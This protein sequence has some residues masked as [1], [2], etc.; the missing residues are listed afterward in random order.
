[1]RAANIKIENV[2]KITFCELQIAFNQGDK[3]L[4]LL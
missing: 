2:Q 4:G 1:M 3:A